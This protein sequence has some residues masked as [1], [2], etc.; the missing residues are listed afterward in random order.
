MK[1][2]TAIFLDEDD[3]D[4][5][6][7][8]KW[9]TKYRRAIIAISDN[10]GEPDFSDIYFIHCSDSVDNCPGAGSTSI[11]E[12]KLHTDKTEIDAIID[13]IIN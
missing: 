7:F 12:Y 1:E 10:A 9:L 11:S 13:S 4:Y 3:C 5:H 6:A 8:Q 2:I